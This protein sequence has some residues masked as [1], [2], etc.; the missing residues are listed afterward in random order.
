[1]K[2]EPAFEDFTDAY[3]RGEPQV[4][5]TSLVADV[6]TP[7]SAFLKLAR[8]KTNSFVLESVEGGAV[9]GRYSFIG[10]EPDLV[11]RCQG[12]MAEINRD[13][14]EDDT[15]FA[16]CPVAEAE[17][18]IASLRSL[19]VESRIDM[20]EERPPMSAGLVG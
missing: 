11:W 4:L 10:M 19:V 3:E 18:A 20:P 1:M 12:N 17:G 9:R 16:P 2:I 8:G 6:E 15:A 13:A 7:V 5:W 14:L